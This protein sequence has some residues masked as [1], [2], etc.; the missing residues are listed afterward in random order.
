MKSR[1]VRRLGWGIAVL[2][3]ALAACANAARIEG[4][5]SVK[6]LSPM[7][8]VLAVG[9]PVARDGKLELHLP[10][11]GNLSVSPWPHYLPQRFDKQRIGIT[12]LLH[13]A[14]PI[15]R[16]S[17]SRGTEDKPW[18]EFVHGA[19]SGSN[20]LGEWQLQRTPRGWSLAGGSTE[21]W[22]GSGAQPGTPAIVPVGGDR[23][24]IYL[25]ESRVPQRHPNVAYEEE[26]QADW[27]AIRLEPGRKRCAW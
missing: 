12:R 4:M 2:P 17:L 24:C 18:L 26:P 8:P 25:L 11:H 6:G 13:P 1:Y 15:D 9:T 22:L 10:E 19:R 21:H 27:A 3:L 20:V 14:G 5:D 23:W 7:A 16:I